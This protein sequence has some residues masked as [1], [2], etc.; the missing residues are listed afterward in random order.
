MPSGESKKDC[1]FWWVYRLL[2][3]QVYCYK[4]VTTIAFLTMSRKGFLC[5]IVSFFPFDTLHLYC[6]Q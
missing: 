2:L 1:L 4:T 3:L 5:P 6:M